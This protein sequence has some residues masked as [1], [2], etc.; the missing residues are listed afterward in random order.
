MEKKYDTDDEFP[1]L[2]NPTIYLVIEGRGR[3]QGTRSITMIHFVVI[4]NYY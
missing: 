1:T 2:E 4:I 3:K